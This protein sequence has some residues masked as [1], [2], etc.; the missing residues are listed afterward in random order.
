[1]FSL[2]THDITRTPRQQAT[3]LNDHQE[4]TCAGFYVSNGHR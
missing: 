2:A 3:L 4:R 1:M